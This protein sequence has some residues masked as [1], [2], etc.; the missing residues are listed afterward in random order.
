MS[1]FQCFYLQC[2][3]V[4]IVFS[5]SV[6]PAIN[7]ILCSEIVLSL[8]KPVGNAWAIFNISIGYY[9]VSIKQVC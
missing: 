2:G 9:Q 6:L 1:E 4:S 8:E 3:N 5:F 7:Q